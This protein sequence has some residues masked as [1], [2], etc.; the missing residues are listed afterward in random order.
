MEATEQ[1]RFREL[2][3]EQRDALRRQLEDMGA[4]P[5]DPNIESM[6]F[7]FGFADSAQSTAERNK[8][9]AVIERLREG[10]H[11]VEL[12]LDKLDKGTYGLCER[13]GEPIGLERLEALP[14]ARLCLSCKQKE[15]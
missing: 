3:N 4:D 6:D 8:V 15:G 14:A 1:A 13:C 2:L 7:D 9:L 5:E 11:D 12:A 10:L